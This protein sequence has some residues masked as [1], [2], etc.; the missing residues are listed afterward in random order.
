[1]CVYEYEYNPTQLILR[2]DTNLPVAL[3]YGRFRGLQ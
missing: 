3:P 1:M 2:Y